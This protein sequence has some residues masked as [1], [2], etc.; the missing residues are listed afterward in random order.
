MRAQLLVDPEVG[1]FIEEMQIVVGQERDLRLPA[2]S[3]PAGAPAP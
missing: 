3:R 2:S 1:P